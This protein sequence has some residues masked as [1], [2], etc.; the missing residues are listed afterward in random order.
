MSNKRT[1]FEE[2]FSMTVALLFDALIFLNKY[3]LNSTF[4]E[5]WY[6]KFSQIVLI[7]ASQQLFTI[8]PHFLIVPHTTLQN[9]K[10]KKLSIFF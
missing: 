10:Q 8:M 6:F 3:W 9:I 4:P 5:C 2:K 7:F 1:D